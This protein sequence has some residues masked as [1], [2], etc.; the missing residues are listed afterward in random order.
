VTKGVF[1]RCVLEC[2]LSNA[3][4]NPVYRTRICATKTGILLVRRSEPNVCRHAVSRQG[5]DSSRDPNEQCR[6]T[7]SSM[8][9]QRHSLQ[10]GRKVKSG[11][12]SYASPP[13]IRA[14][15]FRCQTLFQKTKPV[16][17]HG[18]GLFAEKMSQENS[19]FWGPAASIS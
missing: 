6:S 4:R 13:V 14:V 8:R 1:V 19:I 10:I 18:N 11:A 7:V 3:P 16:S 5:G 9:G 2:S 15:G 12:A 17:R